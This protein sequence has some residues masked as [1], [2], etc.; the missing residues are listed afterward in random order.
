MKIG[1]EFPKNYRASIAKNLLENDL[2]KNNDKKCFNKINSEINY[3]VSKMNEINNINNNLKYHFIIL[4][5]KDT[6]NKIKNEL[7]IKDMYKDLF[8]NLIAAIYRY[9]LVFYKLE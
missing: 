7:I 8:C 6:I 2:N 3:F 1:F 5:Y 9:Y 4:V